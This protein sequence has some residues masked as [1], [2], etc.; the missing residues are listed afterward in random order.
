MFVQSIL[1]LSHGAV[2]TAGVPVARFRDG[3]WTCKSCGAESE[4]F[5]NEVD[6]KK[7]CTAKVL[8][9]ILNAGESVGRGGAACLCSLGEYR[10]C[11]IVKLEN[12]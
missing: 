1:L 11:M 8:E 10:W 3:R 2:S 6:A 5:A 4:A 9:L 7:W 12:C